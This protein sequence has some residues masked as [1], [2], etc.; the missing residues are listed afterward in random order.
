KTDMFFDVHL[1]ISD[2]LTYAKDFANAGADLICFHL[3]SDCD[4]LSVIK[5]IRKY[6]KKVGI[7]VKPKTDIEKIIPFLD[8]IDMVLVMTVEP[9]FGGQSF[10]EDMMPK[11]KRIRELSKDILIQVDGGINNDTIKIVY[12]NGAN[13]AVAGSAVFK[14]DNYKQN[15]LNLRN[16][17]N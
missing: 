3:E 8:Q 9:G 16:A 1:M 4:A 13:V 12:D 7:A 11:I 14:G 5:E 2:P 6:G 15:I 17:I 10:M